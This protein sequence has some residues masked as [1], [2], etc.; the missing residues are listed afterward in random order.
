MIEPKATST[1]MYV[2]VPNGLGA[3]Q[4]D[5]LSCGVGLGVNI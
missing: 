5:R 1:P 4:S 3:S 2:G